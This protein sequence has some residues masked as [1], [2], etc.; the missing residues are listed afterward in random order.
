MFTDSYGVDL[1]FKVNGDLTG[2]TSASV[3]IKPPNNGSRERDAV[4]K[5]G[6]VVSVAEGTVTY[7]TAVGDFTN[8]GTYKLQAIVHFGAMRKLRSDVV[9]LE[10]E[11]A[12]K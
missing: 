4:E 8:T 5:T 9:E 2:A 12:L 1:V 11:E 3:V 6:A 10:V 7:R